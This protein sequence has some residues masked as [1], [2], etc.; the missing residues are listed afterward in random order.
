MPVSC[1]K[2]FGELI[3]FK[4]RDAKWILRRLEEARERPSPSL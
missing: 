1:A 2:G 3:N 4:I